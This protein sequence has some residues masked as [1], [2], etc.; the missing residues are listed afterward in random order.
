MRN[1]KFIV[2]LICVLAGGCT[3][4][5]DNTGRSP[6]V[7]IAT[8]TAVAVSIPPHPSIRVELFPNTSTP[9]PIATEDTCL[10]LKGNISAKGEKI[11]HAPGQAN[12][13]QVE[14]DKE[15]ESYFCTEEQAVE[16]GFRKAGN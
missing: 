6:E 8:K 4:I 9:V 11:Y 12:Y 3:M 7:A 15:G 14:I 1:I 2:A 16:A 10:D 13:N 5:T